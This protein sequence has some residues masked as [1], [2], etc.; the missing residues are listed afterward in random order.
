MEI[1]APRFLK[2]ASLFYSASSFLLLFMSSAS[3][4][5]NVL[6]LG[7][8]GASAPAS[9]A[10]SMRKLSSAYAGPAIRIRRSSDNAVQDFGFTAGGQLDTASLK[11]FVGSGN[12]YVATWYDQSGNNVDLTQATLSQQP[13]LVSGGIIQRENNKPFI[14]FWGVVSVS[15]N[16]LNL[17]FNMTTVGHVSAIIKFVA[18]G[19]GFILS[20]GGTYN[21]HGYSPN[22]TLLIH[23]TFSSVSVRNG[24]AWQDGNAIAPLSFPWPTSL[25]IAE[26]APANPSTNT[27]WNNIGNDRNCCHFL[28]GGSG[29]S[30]LITFNTSLATADRQALE[31]SQRNFFL[32]G[33]TLPVTWHSF[34]AGNTASGV[35]IK[36]ET[37]MEQ[38]TKYFIVQRSSDGSLWTDLAVI[39]ASGSSSDIRRYQ[40]IDH[41]PSP[42]L[43]FY[44]IRQQDIDGRISY[45][46]IRPVRIEPSQNSSVVVRKD[47]FTNRLELRTSRNSTLSLYNGTGSLIWTKSFSRGQHSVELTDLPRGI[48]YIRG[49]GVSGKFLL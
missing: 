28:S 17:P 43:Q 36:W 25:T 14:R 34:T 35:D 11:T 47:I 8:L 44:R 4:A 37:A 9:V 29:Y 19:Y 6:D 32:I 42:G 23:P 16:S 39:T 7:G 33:T 22:S 26:F 12:G 27:D 45:S 13:S 21:W 2:N 41:S 20:S 46:E 3:V 31:T 30:E 48:Y 15:Q 1:H 38:N 5:Q 40:F 24:Q 18:G 10:Y 49:N